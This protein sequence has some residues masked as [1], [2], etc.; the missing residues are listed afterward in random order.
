MFLKTFHFIMKI[1]LKLSE[2]EREIL[3]ILFYLTY[4]GNEIT[5][6]TEKY[7]RNEICKHYGLYKALNRLIG[8]S[9]VMRTLNKKEFCYALSPN[10][11]KILDLFRIIDDLDLEWTEPEY[12]KTLLLSGHTLEQANY[13]IKRRKEDKRY[14]TMCSQCFSVVSVKKNKNYVNDNLCV[15]CEL[16]LEKK[17]LPPK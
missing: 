6:I 2:L 7:L 9:Y 12:L 4:Q 10:G 8:K 3:D 1:A 13:E 16:N 11:K 5:P 17:S 15:D 14:P